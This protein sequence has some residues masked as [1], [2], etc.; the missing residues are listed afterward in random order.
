MF[1]L[2]LLFL[3]SKYSPK[4]LLD[5]NMVYGAT[6]EV[7]KFAYIILRFR[8]KTKAKKK[9]GSNTLTS[10][11]VLKDS[12]NMERQATMRNEVRPEPWNF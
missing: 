1:S 6:K 9:D 7:L 8:P 11:N 3:T 10:I 12:R 4:E 5:I 2:K